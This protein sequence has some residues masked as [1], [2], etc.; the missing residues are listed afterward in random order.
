MKYSFLQEEA[1]VVSKN[2]AIDELVLLIWGL[3]STEFLMRVLKWV[4]GERKHKEDEKRKEVERVNLKY[5][6][7]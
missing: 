5:S 3:D 6:N 2:E 7:I 4:D 1:L